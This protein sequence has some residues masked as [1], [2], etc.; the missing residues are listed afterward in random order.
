MKAAF[1]ERF[2]SE[3][4]FVHGDRPDPRLGPRQVLVRVKS[5]GIN[6]GDLLRREGTYGGPA[7]SFPFIPGWEVAGIVEAMGPEV[8]DRFIGQRVLATLADGGYAEMAAVNRAGAVPIPDGVSF[9]DA[10]SIPMVFLTAW[11]SLLKVARLGPGDTVLI[12]SGGSGVGTAAIQIAKHVGARVITTA[13]TDEKI[14]R[15]RDLGANEA[16]N[17]ERQDFLPEVMRL[18][19]NVGVDVV[20]ESVGGVVLVKSIAA[21]APLGRLVVVGNSSRSPEKSDLDAL[22]KKNATLTSFSL[23]RQMGYGGVMAELGRILE[24]VEKGEL[25]AVVDRTYPLREVADAHRLLAQRRN[26]GKVLLHP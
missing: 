18:T 20:L 14:A 10:A 15:A 22:A 4:A 25:K 2:G 6:R 26:F 24:L 8:K 3:D 16:I 19:G 23:A 12:Q 17:Y 13:G 21:V 11:Y 1:I 5:A 9:D 7:P